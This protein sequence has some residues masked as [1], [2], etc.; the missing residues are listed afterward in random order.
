MRCLLC[1]P[2]AIFASAILGIDEL[3]ADPKDRRVYNLDAIARKDFEFILSPAHGI[4]SVVFRKLRLTS[5]IRRGERITLEADTEGNA[6]AIH[7]LLDTLS[8]SIPITSYYVTQVEL[9]A[10]VMLDPSKPA[11]TVTIRITYP[12]SCSLKYDEADLRL[13]DMLAASGIEPMDRD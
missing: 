8:E 11:T 1:R 10:L 13:R 7:E 2:Q 3:P 6:N 5:R 4:H 12:N 9:A